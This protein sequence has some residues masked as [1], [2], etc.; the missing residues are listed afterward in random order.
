MS[1]GLFKN[2]T[3]WQL[4][5]YKYIY[6]YTSSYVGNSLQEWRLESK[7]DFNWIYLSPNLLVIGLNH[8]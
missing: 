1:F 2:K 8:K 4:F 6:M 5:A 7:N 3:T